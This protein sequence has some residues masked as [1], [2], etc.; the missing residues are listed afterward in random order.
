MKVIVFGARGFIGGAVAAELS[1]SGHEIYDGTSLETGESVNLLDINAVQKYISETNPDSVI[2]CAG[3]VGG[4]PADFEKNVQFT[5]NILEAIHNSGASVKRVVV[6]GS[7]GEYGEVTTLP[8]NEDAPLN[9]R[10]PYAAS[11]IKE[12]QE[13]LKLS[14]EYE[15]PVVVARIFNPLGPNMKERFLIPSLIRQIKAIKEGTSD[16]IEISRLDAKRDYIDVRDIARAMRLIIEDRP[17]RHV[18]NI[19]SGRATSNREILDILLKNSNLEE[20]PKVTETSDSPEPQFAVQAGTSTIQS[21]FGWQP[22]KSIEDVIKEILDE[23]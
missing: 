17:E 14:K 20:S 16:S 15:V 23:E 12:E 21:E 13:A 11:K 18:Y 19:G 4:N 6:C 22:S 3:I 5:H 2:N 8:V 10:S 7:A 9:G 1:Q